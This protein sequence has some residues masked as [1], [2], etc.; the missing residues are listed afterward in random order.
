MSWKLE[1]LKEAQNEFNSLDGSVKL[2]VAKALEKVK[3]NPV[4]K[5]DGGYGDRLGNRFGINLT[6]HYK[7]KLKSSGIRVVYVLVED[8]KMMLTTVIGSRA[9]EEVYR[10][11][12]RRKDLIKDHIAKGEED[13][14][15]G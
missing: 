12:D 13:V 11:A 3:T 15:E 8:N 4:S 14:W 5:Q 9:D 10:I 2:Q 7:I 1:F 6:G